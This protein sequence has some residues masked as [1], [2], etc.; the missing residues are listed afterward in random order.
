M[1][2]LE[3]SNI[4]CPDLTSDKDRL[5]TIGQMEL[6]KSA[7]SNGA[8]CGRSTKEEFLQGFRQDIREA[9]LRSM[10]RLACVGKDAGYVSA[11]D[12]FWCGLRGLVSPEIK[13]ELHEP[14]KVFAATPDDSIDYDKRLKNPRW[15]SILVQGTIDHIE[16]ATL[17]KTSA[18]A[19]IGHF[20]D[21][22]LGGGVA[23][24]GSG[25]VV[26][27]AMTLGSRA[28]CR[29]RWRAL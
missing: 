16:G 26:S 11:R 6:S 22:D 3:P 18:K 15:K 5:E 12:L 9:C 29:T 4:H 8:V 27:P 13:D 14:K 24:P 23:S 2:T 28:L 1:D 7:G 21:T 17:T 10:K 20:Q 19:Y 25:V